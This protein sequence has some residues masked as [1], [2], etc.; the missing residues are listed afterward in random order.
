MRRSALYLHPA[1]RIGPV[2]PRIFGGF[3]EHLGRAVYGGVYEPGSVH[4]DGNGF[5]R[6]VLEALR[7]LRMTAMRYPGG[8]F[9]SGYHWLDGVG[10]AESRP[11]VRESAWKSVEPN[12][13][14]SDEFIRL[15][16]ELDWTPMLTVNLGTGT[17]EEAANWVEYCNGPAGTRYADMRVA[18]GGERPYNVKLWCLGNEMD[19]A[20]QMGHV[21]AR[22]YAVRAQQ[23]AKMM[24]DADPSIELVA[25]GSCGVGMKTYMEWDREVLEYLGDLA[26][27]V[28]LH[29]Y[30]G[31]RNDDT[32]DYLAVT[33]SIDRQIE[34]MDAACRYVQAK[35][36]SAKH[37]YLCFD[38]WNVWYKNHESNGMGRVAPP[39]LEEIY[40][41]EDAL[42]VAGF[43]NS[44]VRH[45]DVVRIANLAQIVN[46][47]A[48][49]LTRGGDL[50]I[51]SIF[52]PFEMFSKRRDGISLQVALDGPNYESPS[53]GAVP[54]LDASAILGEGKLHLFATNRDATESMELQVNITGVSIAS[55]ESA[56]SLSGTDPKVA[57]SFESPAAVAPVPFDKIRIE[58]GHA[59]CVLPPLSFTAMT[60][61]TR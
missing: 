36:R 37:A 25:C 6:D 45:A 14:G 52:H 50:L 15:C 35:R 44:F 20:W 61:K 38:E 29:R 40:N 12:R 1:F 23:A 41:L 34:E 60:L 47:I 19:G 58:D 42:V 46:V 13:F 39:L 43:L 8:N 54:V 32:A 18:N 33:A 53:Y 4:A 27:Y 51:Q 24:K 11:T 7:R 55:L 21:P 56:E 10:P 5:R 48:P 3:L 31:N 16:R 59:I 17:P 2:D 26:D 30:V 28:S 49:I 57:N 22:D 9:A